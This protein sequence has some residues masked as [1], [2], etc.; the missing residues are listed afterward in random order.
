ML[1]GEQRAKYRASRAALAR[2]L[3]GDMAEPFVLR[4]E[5][6]Y[7]RCDVAWPFYFPILRLSWRYLLIRV[8]LLASTPPFLKRWLLRRT[9]MRIGRRVCIAPGGSID[10]FFP[11]LIEIGD[12]CVLGDG[13]RITTHEISAGSLRVG[14]VRIG[15]GSV[16]GANAVVGCGVSIG[17]GA[18]VGAASYV[19]RNVPDGA[20]VLGVPAKRIAPGEDGEAA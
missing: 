6:D 5:D 17:G 16:I 8:A 20:T 19:T 14:R 1:R 7:C 12:D 13:C 15:N 2:Y 3:A 9:G 18:T 11:H 10:N 4:G